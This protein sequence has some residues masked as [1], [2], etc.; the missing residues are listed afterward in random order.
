MKIA[1]CSE[2][3]ED[4][5]QVDGLGF[6]AHPLHGKTSGVC[7]RHSG[8]LTHAA[9]VMV[10]TDDIMRKQR[11]AARKRIEELLAIMAQVDDAFPKKERRLIALRRAVW[12]LDPDPKPV[13]E[14]DKF[15]EMTVL[16]IEEKHVETGDT[17]VEAECRCG[18]RAQ[19]LAGEL[20]NGKIKHCPSGP[21]TAED[22]RSIGRV[23]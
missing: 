6:F 12:G 20:Q 3:G 10:D 22:L 21:H 14:G 23:P 5:Q 1:V 7:S 11:D 4:L 19:R 16:W 9:V 15:N 8:F 2:C 17:V 13:K 18:A